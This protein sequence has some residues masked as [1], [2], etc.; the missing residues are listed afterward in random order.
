MIILKDIFKPRYAVIIN[1]ILIQDGINAGKYIP[2]SVLLPYKRLLNTP[3]TTFY[4][5]LNEKY[6]DCLIICG[7]KHT[8]SGIYGLGSAL[9]HNLIKAIIFNQ[10]YQ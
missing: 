10:R 7:S 3:F 4:K 8:L 1:S 9:P 6:P 5:E 2:V